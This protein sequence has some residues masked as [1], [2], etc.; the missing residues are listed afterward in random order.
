[1]SGPVGSADCPVDDDPHHDAAA[2]AVFERYTA[3]D[4]NVGGIT[5]RRALPKRE[6]RTVGAWCF[7]DHFGPTDVPADPEMQVGPHPHIGLQTVTWLLEGEVVHR[8]SL[9]SEQVIRPGAVNLMTAGAGVSHAE[10]T[11]PGSAVSQHGVQ[12]WVAQPE[13]TRHGAPE[14]VHLPDLPR[15]GF[16]PWQAT[17]L[18]GEVAGQRSPARTDTPLVGMALDI[19]ESGSAVVPLDPSFEHGVVVLEG[20]VS[21]GGERVEPSG[22]VYLGLGRSELHVSARGLTRLLVLGGEPFEE[23]ISMWWNFVGR[24][25]VELD[26]AARAWN[27]GSDRFGQVDS[28]LA[29]IAAP[30]RPFKRGE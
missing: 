3:R 27:D 28:T 16:G 19:D 22:L 26:E 13:S 30:P 18:V 24:G 21:V 20:T 11:P 12:L 17:V 15:L 29:R 5:V 9:G 8:D 7:V 10:Q 6:R 25:H 23:E 1:M 2:S 14:F 4:A